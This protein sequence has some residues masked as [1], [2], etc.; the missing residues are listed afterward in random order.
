MYL[1]KLFLFCSI[2]SEYIFP[3]VEDDNWYSSDEED[4][5][6]SK[7]L[8]DVLKNINRQVSTNNASFLKAIVKV[9]VLKKVC[10]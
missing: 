8:T 3:L 5:K 4:Q 7:K 1:S 9:H 10:D 6:D 2:H